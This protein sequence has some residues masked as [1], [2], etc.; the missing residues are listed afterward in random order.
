M[1]FRFSRSTASTG[2]P[3]SSRPGFYFDK[4]KRVVIA[5][6]NIDLASAAAAKVAIEDLVTVTLQKSAR[7]CLA[8]SAAPEMTGLGDILEREKRLR[9]RLERSAMDWAR[10]EFMEF[11]Q[12]HLGSV[13]FVLAEAILRKLCAKVTHHLVARNLRDDAGGSDGQTKAIAVD[14]SGL[15]NRER[16]H[17]QS[18]DQH[19]F[20]R[21][22]Q[23]RNRLA[24]RS[25][26]SAQ[27]INAIDLRGIDNANG[28]SDFGIGISS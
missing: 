12:M 7:Q 27:N 5:T 28:P 16:D 1:R 18:I 17:R 19:M 15:R 25:M 14:D 23:S 24:H 2:R 4:N 26:G 9:H 6:D 10:A 22:D 11:Q 20:R 21:I 3:K 13:T 8:A